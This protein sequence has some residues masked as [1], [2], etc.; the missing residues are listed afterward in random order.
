V[1]V[2]ADRARDLAR[3]SSSLNARSLN[4][5]ENVCSGRSI[6]RA[7]SAA[8]ALLSMPPERNMP[9]GTSAIRRRRTDSSSS[10]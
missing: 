6:M 7:I 3:V 1:R 5:T 8:I 10:S 9:S 4:A 2:G